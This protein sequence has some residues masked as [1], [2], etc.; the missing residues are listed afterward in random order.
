V[1][2]FPNSPTTGQTFTAAGVTWTWDGVKWTANGLNVAYLPLQ[3]GTMLGPLTLVGN[4]TAPLMAAP[5]QYID[6]LPVMG[7][8]RIIN[9][10]MRIDQRNNGATGTATGYTIDRWV[11]DASQASKGNWRRGGAAVGFGGCLVF[12]S[13]SA[14]ASAASDYFQFFQLV[15]ADAVSDFQWGTAAAQ[16]VTL[17]FWVN[18]SI[19][20]TFAGAIVND[21][22]T[23]SY[24]FNYTVAANT[25]TKIVVTISGDTAGTWVMSGNARALIVRFDLGSGSTYR[26]PANAWA[27]ANYIGVT[28]AV[29]VVAVNAA[30]FNLTG[31]KLEVG[32]VATPFN[33]QSLT[34]SMADCQRY[35]IGT[36][37]FV[38]GGYGSSSGTEYFPVTFPVTMRAAPTMNFTGSGGIGYTAVG[39][40]TISTFGFSSSVSPVAGP[41]GYAVNYNWNASAEL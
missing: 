30:T 35:F 28:G 34:K 24:P 33:R 15:E 25:W 31:V 6:A 1:I 21:A 23:R 3:G 38:L 2:D 18:S 32:G 22:G 11:Y 12:T 37:T 39:T 20:G 13:T 27:S 7:D 14:F 16:P 8:N 36:Q 9:G 17:S 40:G 19:A 26:G 5:K 41:A 29:S 10:D 4:P